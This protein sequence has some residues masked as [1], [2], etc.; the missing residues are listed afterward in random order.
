MISLF[1]SF[2]YKEKQ[3]MSEEGWRIQRSK[4]YVTNRNNKYEDRSP[5]NHMPNITV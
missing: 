3:E 1:E 2:P 4:R 5:K